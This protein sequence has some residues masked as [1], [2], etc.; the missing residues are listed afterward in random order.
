[1]QQIV[2]AFLAGSVFYITR[3]V[4]GTLVVPILLH[5]WIDFTTLAFS[6]ATAEAE[7][8]LGILGLAQYA[9]FLLAIIALVVVLRGGDR[10]PQPSQHEL[11]RA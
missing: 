1:V 10:E 4:S 11:K 2:I 3:R 6:E 8:P 9:A 5:A 7:S